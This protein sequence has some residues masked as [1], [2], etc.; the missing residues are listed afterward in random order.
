[1]LAGRAPG[2]F[3][4][5]EH[6]MRFDYG[7]SN[8]SSQACTQDVQFNTYLAGHRQGCDR[9]DRPGREEPI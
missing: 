3:T 9:G 1:M 7:A 4:D 8:K 2:N 5:P 6:Q